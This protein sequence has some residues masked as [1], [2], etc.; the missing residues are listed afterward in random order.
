MKKRSLLALVGTIVALLLPA[1]KA[2]AV[3]YSFP[4]TFTFTSCGV[5]GPTGPTLSNCQSAYSNA[6]WSSNSSYYTVT[7]GIQYWT[8]PSTATYTFIL[9]GGSAAIQGR[10]RSIQFSYA[11]TQGTVLKILVGQDSTAYL[12]QG[13]G[14]GGGTFV[15]TSS[16]SIIGIAGG[17]GGYGTDATASDPSS[18]GYGGTGGAAAS[19]GAAGGVGSNG[20]A[21]PG[22]GFTYNS[23]STSSTAY[24][25]INGGAGG[26]YVN[27]GQ[28]DGGDGGFGGGGGAMLN[29]ISGPFDRSGGGGGYSGGGGGGYNG[30]YASNGGGGGS[31]YVSGSATAVN[32]SY[33]FNTVNT[34]GSVQISGGVPSLTSPQ[35]PIVSAISGSQINVSE[36]STVANAISYEIDVYASNGTSFIESVTVTTSN[37]TS[38]NTLTGLSP[39]T[40]YQISVTA[41]GDGVSYG[42]SPAGPQTMITMG[43]GIT[44]ITITLGGSAAQFQINGTTLITATITGGAGAGKVSYY[45]N[46]KKIFRC[47]NLTTAGISSTCSW[48]PSVHG[49]AILTATYVPNNSNYLS[50][51]STA[52]AANVIPRSS[53]RGT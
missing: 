22:A 44:G 24:S 29:N 32:T 21:A 6:A 47:I 53:T 13:C 46:N 28:G 25:F 51:T 19:G 45:Y 38:S 41:N 18:A 4:T 39:N 8:V 50:S 12:T 36:T 48:K 20:A 42:S 35:A 7:S 49:I 52:I 10:G 40:T 33:G 11:L 3:L 15:T 26:P 23:S 9:T 31:S 16:N 17:G 37:I 27:G 2:N 34:N 5:S 1:A 14:G 30:G 43:A